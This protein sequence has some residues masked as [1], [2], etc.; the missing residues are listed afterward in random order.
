MDYETIVVTPIAGALG[1]EVAGVDLAGPLADRAL[2][3]IGRA[4][5]DHLVLFFRG[6]DLTPER[7]LAFAVRLGPLCRV[8]YIAPHPDHPDIIAVLKEADERDISTFGVPGIR[9]SASWS[10]RRRRPCSTPSTCRRWAATPCGPTC[11]W[12]TR[13]CPA[14]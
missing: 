1:A 11:T 9:T 12:R 10:G 7:Q 3:E 13:R 5:T 4:F 6:Q 2:A 14:A 8:P